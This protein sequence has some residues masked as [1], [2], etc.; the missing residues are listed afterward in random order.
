[1]LIRDLRFHQKNKNAIETVDIAI[2]YIKNPKTKITH[3]P[4]RKKNIIPD[5]LK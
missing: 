2:R 5:Y 1:M 3:N 4:Y